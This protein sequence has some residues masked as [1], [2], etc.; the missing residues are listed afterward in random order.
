[1]NKPYDPTDVRILNNRL[2][3][4]MGQ[5]KAVERMID[6]GITCE[7]L[8]IQVNAVKSAMHSF[9]KAVL[10]KQ[11]AESLRSCAGGK[12]PDAEYA[13]LKSTIGRFADLD[14]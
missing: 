2:N 13:E 10:E 3:K 9:G 8:I 6:E 14:K 12:D 4:I 7:D 1:M 5:L 11:L